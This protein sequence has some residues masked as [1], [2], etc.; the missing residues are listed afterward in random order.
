MA[1]NQV[2]LS[3]NADGKPMSEAKL[4]IKD[5]NTWM[6]IGP[7]WQLYSLH[8]FCPMPEVSCRVVDLSRGGYDEKALQA[9]MVRFQ[10]HRNFARLEKAILQSV[11]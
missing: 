11:P 8:S 3:V 2:Y 1:G 10:I 5:A 6:V 7:D 9:A 4:A